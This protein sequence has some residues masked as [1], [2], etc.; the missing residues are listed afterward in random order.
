MKTPLSA[1]TPFGI[2]AIF[3][4]CPARLSKLS[5]DCEMSPGARKTVSPCRKDAR[6]RLKLIE[7][8]FSAPLMPLRVLFRDRIDRRGPDPSDLIL[9][10]QGRSLQQT[11]EFLF[12]DMMV[13]PLARNEVRNLLVT[14]FE[15]LEL[16]DPKI[17]IALLP[18][19]VLGEF[20]AGTLASPRGA[21]DDRLTPAQ[22][23]FS[24]IR[25]LIDLPR[26]LGPRMFTRRRLFL[27]HLT[28]GKVGLTHRA[29]GL[30]GMILGFRLEALHRHWGSHL[31]HRIHGIQCSFQSP[32]PRGE[33][34]GEKSPIS[35]SGNM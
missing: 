5:G 16:N 32:P 33:L 29:E 26:W 20:H 30:R 2:L 9:G 3:R 6:Q 14:H 17:V 18:D 13:L 35:P 25:P 28:L 27:L 4:L 19:L 34:N 23:L 21:V 31:V 11:A 1:P 15:T 22:E 10:K 24:R 12:A 8:P 7:R